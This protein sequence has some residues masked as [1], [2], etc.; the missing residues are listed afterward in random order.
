[1]NIHFY[2]KIWIGITIV[3]VIVMLIAVAFAGFGFGVQLPGAAG[4]IDPRTLSKTAPF[5]KP[6]VYEVTAGKYQ[7]VMVAQMW[8]FKP[9]EIRIP[10]GSTVT[11]TSTSK[12]VTHGLYIENTDINIMILPGQVSEVTAKFPKAGTYS[13]ICHEYCG[14]GHQGMAGKVIVEP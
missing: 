8:M 13:I 7:V 2:E 1:M 5:D 10:A 14:S 3:A 6:G 4:S 9:A 12:D 11:F